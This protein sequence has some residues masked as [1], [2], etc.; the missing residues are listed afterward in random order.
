MTEF[1]LSSLKE[2]EFPKPK[3]NFTLATFTT[4]SKSETY[5]LNTIYNIMNIRK[6]Y[7]KC[8]K[9]IPPLIRCIYQFVN[10]E[11]KTLI[12][13]TTAYLTFS[14]NY[15]ITKKMVEK[16]TDMDNLVKGYEK[17]ARLNVV[18]IYDIQF[19]KIP[20]D[21]LES[22]GKRQEKEHIT[23]DILDAI[24]NHLKPKTKKQKKE[25]RNQRNQRSQRSQT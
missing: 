20:D 6:S 12:Q 2:C 23:F 21:I 3:N 4:D 8:I 9:S 15:D 7:N 16:N 5:V 19:T 25:L 18:V 17:S 24:T 10:K 1:Y 14:K 11:N 22:F 13:L